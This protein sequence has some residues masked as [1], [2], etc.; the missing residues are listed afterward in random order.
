MDKEV[1]I[2]VKSYKEELLN[3]IN[4]VRKEHSQKEVK[5]IINEELDFNEK[6]LS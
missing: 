2:E 5:T 4:K 6:T 1:E 3:E